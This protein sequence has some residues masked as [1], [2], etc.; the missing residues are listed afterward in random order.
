M[1]VV[2][3]FI[4]KWLKRGLGQWRLIASALIAAAIIH[5]LVTLSSSQIEEA[6]SFRVLSEGLPVNQ[7]AFG[8]PVTYQNQPLAF[9][10]ADTLYSFCLY[11]ASAS[12]IGVSAKL[13]DAGWS[14]S[15]HTPQGENFYYLPGSDRRDTDINIVL[16]PPGNV[17]AI[18][19][20]EV[21]RDTQ[22][23][24]TIKLPH[25]RG[26]AILRAPIKGFAYRRQVDE[27][28]AAFRCQALSRTASRLR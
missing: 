27:L 9:F 28:R 19:S 16:E 24:P 2:G 26:L 6:T 12:R 15:L 23:V 4:I 5:I 3:Q 7:V 21:S 22:S 17:F 13:P 18:G 10:S 20:V 11:D 8:K 14:L 1:N 25:V